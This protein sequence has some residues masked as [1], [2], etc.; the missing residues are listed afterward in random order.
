MTVVPFRRKTSLIYILTAT[1]FFVRWFYKPQCAVIFF[2]N[3]DEEVAELS[4]GRAV[5]SI[6]ALA[7]CIE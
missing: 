1:R 5:F 3:M 7:I 4:R 2:P 6:N